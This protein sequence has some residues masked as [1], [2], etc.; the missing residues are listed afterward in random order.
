MT[1][2]RFIR[3]LYEK[4]KYMDSYG[5]CV[6]ITFAIL[7]VYS[8]IFGYFYILGDLKQLR[9]NWATI[10]CHPGYI[11]F[12][13]IINKP[14]NKTVIQYTSENFNICIGRVLKKVTKKSLGGLIGAN[15]NLLKPINKLTDGTQSNR[16]FFQKLRNKNGIN[17]MS[18]GNKIG[19]LSTSITESTLYTRDTLNKIL[20][21]VATT[22]YGIWGFT[23]NARSLALIYI[24]VVIS[25]ILI[26]IGVIAISL[27]AA[28]LL[29]LIPFVGPFL[30]A[31]LFI[32][33]FAMYVFLLV[34]IAVGIPGI[35]TA[36]DVLKKSKIAS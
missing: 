18:I 28:Q 7:F 27:V 34:V 25:V 15:K 3:K 13:G 19:N 31:A 5:D 11:P 8:G 30:A 35:M 23:M 17:F 29:I 21:V 9:R 22:V 4:K 14:A 12:A 16:S 26:M 20:A 24:L 2:S 6:A 1:I 10:R 33:A 32:T 36:N